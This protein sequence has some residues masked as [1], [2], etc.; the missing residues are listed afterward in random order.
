MME[1]LLFAPG[2]FIGLTFHEF[3]H[4]LS[5]KLLGDASSARQGRLTLNPFAH[6]SPAGTLALFILK[7]GWAKPVQVNIYNFKRPRLYFLLTALAGPAMNILLAGLCIAAINVLPVY[8]NAFRILVYGAFI[9]GILALINLLPVPPLDGSKIWPLVFPKLKLISYS[10]KQLIFALLLIAAIYLDLFDFL[11]N[12]VLR[13]I[14]SL[15]I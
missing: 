11:I 2:I 15:I 10:R 4:S 3:A 8:D 13:T 12:F 9:N 5:A 7:F 6:L 1:L 14:D